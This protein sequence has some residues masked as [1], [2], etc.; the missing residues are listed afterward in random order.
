M[1]NNLKQI[2]EQKLTELKLTLDKDELQNYYNTHTYKETAEYYR[3][4]YG[5]SIKNLKLLFIYFGIERKGRGSN[6][7]NDREKLKQGMI[8]KYGVDNPQKNKEIRERT[9]RTN[10]ARYGTENVF[11]NA[12]IQAK[13]KQT[14]LDRYGVPNAFQAE[15]VKN[16]IKHT[17]LERY[18]VEH[19]SKRKETI[20]KTKQ[21][22]LER[23]G[24]AGYHNFEQA[25][26]TNLKRYGKVSPA[27]PSKAKQ[28]CLARYGV[29][30]VTKL[31]DTHINAAKT[32]AKAVASDGTVFDSGWEVI[33][34]E[35][36]KQ[37]NYTIERQIPI[38]YNGGN[39]TTFIDFKING[40]LYE[41]KGTHLLKNCWVDKGVVIDKKMECYQ[42]NNIIVIT[43]TRKLNQNNW[44]IKFLDIH[45]L[46]F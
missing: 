26:N 30:S 5:C 13:Q 38:R 7:I 3:I 36:A 15:A 14:C 16:T 44:D 20:I 32:R 18:G 10:L 42:E 17:C 31:R 28:T 9:C 11:Q 4:T 39:Q 24:D 1:A 2:Q 6:L 29:D 41:V 8:D 40:Q 22:K 34:Y 27:N 46:T 45:N 12:E 25:K 35:Y 21:T 43:D 23:Y 37:K 33:V 19:I